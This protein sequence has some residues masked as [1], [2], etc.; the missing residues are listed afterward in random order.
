MSDIVHLKVSHNMNCSQDYGLVTQKA[1]KA[2][3]PIL[4]LN[5]EAAKLIELPT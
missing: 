1:L 5:I 4:F 3:Y 2:F